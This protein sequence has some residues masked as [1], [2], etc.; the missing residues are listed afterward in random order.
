MEMLRS[1]KVFL[2]LLSA[3]GLLIQ[4]LLPSAARAQ[5]KVF[6]LVLQNHK[7]NIETI[8]VKAGEKF[9]IRVKNKD[10][11]FEEFESRSLVI[12]KFLKPG[13]EVLVNVG[14]LKPGE[15]DY[16]AEFHASTGKGKI[17]ALP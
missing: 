16:F 12:E 5:E 7:F 17:V 15:Y 13:A 10:R 3:T 2:A 1:K 6:E 14:P 8:E 4:A 11:N 9:K